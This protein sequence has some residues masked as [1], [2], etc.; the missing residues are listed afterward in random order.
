MT[1]ILIMEIRPLERKVIDFKHKTNVTVGHGSATG[2][3]IIAAVRS[4][5]KNLKP[6]RLIV[7]KE[8][9]INLKLLLVLKTETLHQLS[10]II[11]I[12]TKLQ[13]NKLLI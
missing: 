12:L 9:F 3:A 5:I 1:R 2:S 10:N 7:E 4:V 13:V 8:I 11:G 6:K